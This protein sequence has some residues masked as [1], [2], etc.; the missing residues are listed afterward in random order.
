MCSTLFGASAWKNSIVIV[1][2]SVSM[3]IRGLSGA[4][5]RTPDT[6][7]TRAT[8]SRIDRYICV[9]LSGDADLRTNVGHDA[10]RTARV[11]RTA[12][13]LPP[14]HEP[15]VDLGPVAARHHA[16]ER[17]LGLVG[18]TRRDPSQP[19]GDAVH[20]SIHAD[21]RPARKGQDEHE[22]GRLA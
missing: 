18:R 6:R 19:I 9:L 7:A 5:A 20:V 16:V 3:I 21:V 1:P 12:D 15:E 13:V 11:D 2:F 17:L 4:W 22:I 14:R 8:R 10:G